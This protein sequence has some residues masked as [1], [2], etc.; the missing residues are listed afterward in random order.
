MSLNF[1][2]KIYQILENE[3]ADIIRWHSNGHSFRIFDHVRFE[4]EIIPKYFRRKLLNLRIL[5]IKLTNLSFLIADKQ[6]ASVQRQLNLYGF[7][8]V[9]R[10]EDKGAI[11][12]PQFHRGNW[13]AAKN[14]TRYLPNK[15]TTISEDESNTDNPT[16]VVPSEPI[17]PERSPSPEHSPPATDYSSLALLSSPDDNSSKKAIKKVKSLSDQDNNSA[18]T[19]DTPAQ[20]PLTFRSF[21]APYP[22]YLLH[23]AHTHP[24]SL[25]HAQNGKHPVRHRGWIP[26]PSWFYPS[27]HPSSGPLLP[28]PVHSATYANEGHRGHGNHPIPVHHV[29]YSR[30]PYI[31]VKHE[32][33]ENYDQPPSTNTPTAATYGGSDQCPPLNCNIPVAG[34]GYYE[35]DDGFDLHPDDF[36]ALSESMD[37]PAKKAL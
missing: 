28:I 34:N 8:V 31:Q 13:E 6:F 19:T 11:Y 24:Q 5:L 22:S 17:K 2:A 12:H 20:Q 35:Y 3:S 15:K 36:L 25:P 33:P 14:I 9:S 29:H 30:A 32:F 27:G 23:H 1:P 21:A 7:K 10:G 37:I 26:H 18:N 4:R 16:V